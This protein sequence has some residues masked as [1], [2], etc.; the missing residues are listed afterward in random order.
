MNEISNFTNTGGKINTS[1][2]QKTVF[3][4]KPS[5]V[6]IALT[7][8]NALLAY[9]PLGWGG[10]LA[11]GL[12]GFGVLGWVYLKNRLSIPSPQQPF[13]SQELYQPAAWL[14]LFIFALGLAARL[15]RQ[16]S[17]LAFPAV[18]EMENAYS[19]IHLN[20]HWTWHLF[21]R[22]H[23]VPVLYLWLLAATFKIWGFS[24]KVL[25]LVP[26]FLSFLATVFYYLA[27]RV[28]FT[29]SFSFL[30]LLFLSLTFWPVFIGCYSHEAVLMVLFQSMTFWILAKRLKADPSGHHPILSICFGLFLGVGFYTYFG[31]PLVAFCVVFTLGWY[32]LKTRPREKNDLYYCLGTALLVV[33]PLA[34][35]GLKENFGS[36][37]GML[38]IFNGKSDEVIHWHFWQALFYFTDFFWTGWPKCYS[39]FYYYYSGWGGLL[40]PVLGS[41]FFLGTVEWWRIRRNPMAKWIGISSVVLFVPCLLSNL[42]NG[43][44]ISSLLPL[45][46]VTMAM[47]LGAVLEGITKVPNRFLL[48]VPFVLLSLVLDLETL[49]RSKPVANS[50]ISQMDPKVIL[51]ETLKNISLTQGPGLVYSD[52]SMDGTLPVF[53]E[54]GTYSFNALANPSLDQAKASWAA[55]V[56]DE[57]FKPYLTKLFPNAAF[58]RWNGDSPTDGNL[59]SII[60]LNNENRG[61]LGAWRE[62]EKVMAEMDFMQFEHPVNHT[63]DNLIGYLGDKGQLFEGNPFLGFYYWGKL[64]NNYYWNKQY[65]LALPALEKASQYGCDGMVSHNLG[66]VYLNLGR[67]LEAKKALLEAAKYDPRYQP[68]PEVLRKLDELAGQTRNNPGGG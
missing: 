21:F 47:G 57:G 41:L 10:K 14:V 30:S 8:L 32:F 42:P 60:P 55:L 50:D 58:S 56:T 11:I 26:A 34:A 54:L 18:D 31:W 5:I 20:S 51:C 15:Y 45:F 13:F 3:V 6:F 7:A 36:Y 46:I 39:Y 48:M 68:S 43:Y 59:L 64:G 67:Y 1:H 61:T 38:S 52:F 12:F 33:L 35:G 49:T 53:L 66:F 4:L 63:Y 65:D 25:W 16:T 40:N 2:E 24:F 17:S 19:A 37:F 44:H 29:K 27:F 23:Q 28:F 22:P 9:S 62:A